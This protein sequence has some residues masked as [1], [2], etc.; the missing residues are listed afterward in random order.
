MQKNLS[1]E[2]HLFQFLLKS[3]NW[4][5]CNRE[6][7][8]LSTLRNRGRARWTAGERVQK[9]GKMTRRLQ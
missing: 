5:S 4:T 2:N 9:E 6:C 3:K 1:C 8:K 7:S